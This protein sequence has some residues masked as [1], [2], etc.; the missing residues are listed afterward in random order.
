MAKRTLLIVDDEQDM[1][2]LCQEILEG[3]E[4]VD[5]RTCNRSPQALESI[6]EQGV[7]LLVADIAM[8]DLTGLDL[9]RAVRD[10]DKNLPVL[11]M[12]GYPTVD[13]AVQALRLGA[14]DYLTKPFHPDELLETA[15]RLL[16]NVR[17][18]SEHYLL[19]RH[20]ARAFRFGDMIGAS[21]QMSR[22]F[23]LVERVA[24]SGVPV[25][26]TG[27]T[28]T[29]KELV[30]RA[31]H[32]GMRDGGGRFVPVDCGAIPENLLESEFF[33]YEAGAFSGANERS[34]GLMEYADGGVLF[35][36]EIAELPVHLQAKLLRALQEHRIRRIGG[37]REIV[38]DLRLIAATNRNLEE[39]VAAGRFRE[40]LYYRL[41]VVKIEVPPLR[42]RGADISLLVAHFLRA[43]SEELGREPPVLEKEALEVLCT[44]AWPGNVRELQNA[45][46]RMLV[47]SKS[48]VLGI[49]D[50][51][52]SVVL[53]AQIAT[54]APAQGFF[55]ERARQA[56]KFE[57]E[58]LEAV[59]T[60]SGGNVTRAA[61]VAGVPR[62]TLYRLLK[63]CD[64]DPKGFRQD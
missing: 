1:L 49:Q 25:L 59:L 28:G 51:P 34:I 58:Y 19:A 54:D 37:R 16:E 4:D 27:E 41:N 33:G 17:L 45:V 64:L 30:A 6:Q 11:L 18:R 44:Y 26:V 14:A 10:I 43:V 52:E 29:G 50:L 60:Q 62:G 24:S 42:E 53:N 9:L 47:L 12:T 32:R 20:V 55:Q 39:E 21:P 7:D 57:R 48:E 40:D 61:E 23:S 46:R 31:L 22:V 8:P 3:L 5:V 63:R 15:R 2:D 35:L 56:K 36:D 13:T 38:L